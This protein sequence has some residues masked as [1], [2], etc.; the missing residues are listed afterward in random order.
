MEGPWDKY[1]KYRKVLMIGTYI[2]YWK[3]LK[4]R[5]FS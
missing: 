3:V 5:P 2:K 1:L 4:D